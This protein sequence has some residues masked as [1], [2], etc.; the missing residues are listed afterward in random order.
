MKSWSKLKNRRETVP[1][2]RWPLQVNVVRLGNK[3]RTYRPIG[4]IFT[5]KVHW[6]HARTKYGKLTKYPE[7]CPIWDIEHEQ[8][9][10]KRCPYCDAG[11]GHVHT[12]TQYL[13]QCID[14]DLQAA[15]PNNPSKYMVT[16]QLPEHVMQHMLELSRDYLVESPS[17]IEGLD[18]SIG[19]DRNSQGRNK[20]IVNPVGVSRLS[21]DERHLRK[22]NYAEIVKPKPKLLFDKNWKTHLEIVEELHTNTA[23]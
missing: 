2:T 8:V 3:P 13:L 12:T 22:Y 16:L 18:L 23:V 9:S 11:P 20:Y 4:D 15:M 14:R 5:I 1:T 6:V 10:G 7:V 19:Y 17:D 21:E